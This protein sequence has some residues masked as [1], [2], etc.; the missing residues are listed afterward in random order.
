MFRKYIFIAF[1]LCSATAKAQLYSSA[2][3]AQW[4]ILTPLS[5]KDYIASTSAA[6][7]RIGFT[8]FINDKF[9][10]G[11][12][13]GYSTLDDYTPRQTYTYP[14]GA[15]TTDF[16]NYLYY[17][18]IMANGQYYFKQGERFIPY[19]SLAMGVA[20]SEY[21]IFYNVY[22]EKDDRTGFVARPE[23]GVLFKVK[24]YSGWALKSSLSFD[25]AV[26]GST[27]FNIGNLSGIGFQ[28]GAVF[29]TD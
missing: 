18:T 22:E 14:G 26:N 21:R 24:E 2:F 16:Y 4:S 25:Y 27:K 8:K 3:H 20:F 10:V 12:E 17:Y 6:G 29:F 28:I 11:L 9:G 15:F 5:D 23:V 13:G 19:A 1:L 7:M